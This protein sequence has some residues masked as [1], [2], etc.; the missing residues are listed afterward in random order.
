MPVPE[1]DVPCRAGRSGQLDLETAPSPGPFSAQIRPPWA[2]TIVR[3][4]DRPSP[5][6]LRLVLKNESKSLRQV[7]GRDAVTAI[8]HRDVDAV[9]AVLDGHDDRAPCPR[10]AR[11]SHPWR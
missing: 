4:I 10:A 5:M 6:P 8:A 7:L 2:S 11:P 9:G 1:I 3:A